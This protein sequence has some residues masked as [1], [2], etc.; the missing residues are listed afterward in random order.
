MAHLRTSDG[1]ARGLLLY[2]RHVNGP[3]QHEFDLLGRCWTL[4]P[5]VFSPAQTP[6]TRLFTTWLEYPAGGR[7]L[8]VG[9]GAGV[10]AVT[11]ALHGCQVVAL[12]IAPAAVCNTR[13]NAARHGV[14]ERVDA[15]ESDLF[16][17]LSD[18]ER[19][20]VIYWNSNWAL[21]P[22]DFVPGSDLQHAFFDPG[23]AAHRRYIA[24]AGDHLND[25]GRLLLAFSDLASWDGLCDACC[26]AGRVPRVIRAERR[27]LEVSIEFQLVELLP[28]ARLASDGVTGGDAR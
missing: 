5:G 6:A 9:P 28:A 20:D 4:L 15:R 10:T 17:A 2:D 21:P 11:A 13:A 1:F 27:E 7:F 3:P 24:E 22:V 23:Y 18:D 14:G 16:D 25:G 19:F 8:E 26:A 12:D